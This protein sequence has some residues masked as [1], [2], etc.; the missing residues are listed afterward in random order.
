MNAAYQ[1]EMQKEMMEHHADMAENM[2]GGE[3]LEFE[4]PDFEDGMFG[5]GM[6]GMGMSGMGMGMGAGYG[7]SSGMGMGAGMGMG[8]GYGMAQT[9]VPVTGVRYKLKPY[10][11]KYTYPVWSQIPRWHSLKPHTTTHALVDA[12]PETHTAATRKSLMFPRPSQRLL[13]R[14]SPFQLKLTSPT[15]LA[16]ATL[17]VLIAAEADDQCPLPLLAAALA[18]LRLLTAADCLPQN[19]LTKGRPE[20]SI[21]VLSDIHSKRFLEFKPPPV[22]VKSF[23]CFSFFFG[24]ENFSIS[25]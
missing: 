17:P 13:K 8:R 7:M 15:C 20:T 16:D 24:S 10:T 3:G 11:Y 21:M 12:P 2:Y 9:V 22:Y 6:S 5:Y 18:T 19:G 14:P 25:L 23:L 1:M 4:G